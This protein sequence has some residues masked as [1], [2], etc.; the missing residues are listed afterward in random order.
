MCLFRSHGSSV[1]LARCII[2]CSRVEEVSQGAW[3]EC[4]ARV[5]PPTFN[6]LPTPMNRGQSSM[7]TFLSLAA[8]ESLREELAFQSSSLVRHSAP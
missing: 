5:G 3:L 2:I 1:A 7:A 6:L 4:F 8:G